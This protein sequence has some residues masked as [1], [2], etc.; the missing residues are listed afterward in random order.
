M[1][2]QRGVEKANGHTGNTAQ[3]LSGERLDVIAW[4]G[5]EIVLLEEIV[6][7]HAEELRYEAYMVPMVEPMK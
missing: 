4:E 5:G 2:A 1:S 3:E 6:Y 7:T